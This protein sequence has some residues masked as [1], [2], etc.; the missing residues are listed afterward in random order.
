VKEDRVIKVSVLYPNS[1]GCKFDMSYYLNQHMPMVQEKLGTACKRVAVEEGVAGGAPGMP[2]TYIAMGHLYFDS[3]DAFQTAF[4][5][6]SQAILADIPN[7]TNVQP[8]IQISEVK[9]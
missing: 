8:T 3:T 6:H 5:P 4:A 7:Y 9:L 1:A 2:A